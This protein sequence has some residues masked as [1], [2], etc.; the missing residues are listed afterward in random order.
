MGLPGSGKTTLAS[1]LAVQSGG[2]HLS[3]GQWLRDRMAVGDQVAAEQLRAS[4][5][6]SRP[7]FLRFLRESLAQQPGHPGMLIIDG[8]PRTPAQVTWLREALADGDATVIGVHL[9]LPSAMAMQRLASRAPRHGD[10][11]AADPARRIAAEEPGLRLTLTAF[12][13]HWPLLT[14]NAGEVQAN[15]MNDVISAVSSR[16]AIPSS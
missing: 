3:A 9:D 14:V 10:G 16:R 15:V 11:A 12:G 2:Q 6:M 5:T 8:A 1:T 4:A 7:L 13:K